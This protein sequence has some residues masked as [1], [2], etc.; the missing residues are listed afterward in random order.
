MNA[1]ANPQ[2]KQLKY[3]LFFNLKQEGKNGASDSLNTCPPEQI[4]TLSYTLF[5]RIRLAM[6]SHATAALE[7]TVTAAK[8]NMDT[9][10]Y[11]SSEQT[12]TLENARA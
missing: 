9:Y 5:N 3:Y 12:N 1:S 7:E 2:K 10:R 11:E 8:A 6:S 4:S